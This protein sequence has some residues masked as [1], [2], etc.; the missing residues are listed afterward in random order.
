[1]HAERVSCSPTIYTSGFLHIPCSSNPSSTRIRVSVV[2]VS[3]CV[4][5]SVGVGVGVG[6]RNR[7]RV[8]AL[9]RLV[10]VFVLILVVVFV[11]V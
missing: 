11:S 9:I 8:R 6:V 7:V 1:M 3:D 5:N 4:S 10:F 2:D